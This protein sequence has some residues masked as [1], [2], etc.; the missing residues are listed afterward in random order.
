MSSRSP[1]WLCLWPGLA[2]LWVL[3]DVI[4]LIV[5]LGFG[6]LLQVALAVTFL[7][8][9]LWGAGISPLWSA[10]V[11][12]VFVLWFWVAGFRAG[13]KFCQEVSSEG[14]GT[15][16]TVNQLFR[17][18]QTSYLKGHWIEAE[19]SLQD[20]LARRPTDVEGRLLLAGIYRRTKRWDLAQQE[21]QQV[22]EMPQG[23]RWRYEIGRELKILHSLQEEAEG[24]GDSQ[25]AVAGVVGRSQA[26]SPTRGA[27]VA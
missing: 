3:G 10:G 12:W 2:R 17:D 23:G 13:R 26:G 15:D 11:T 6:V 14:G 21:L 24:S 20:L 4:S 16:E 22:Q 9:E 5:A 1:F 27:K 18:A 8:P 7:W 25:G 19:T